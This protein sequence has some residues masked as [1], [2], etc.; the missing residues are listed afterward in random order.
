MAVRIPGGDVVAVE[1][2]GTRDEVRRHGEPVRKVPEEQS[3][4]VAPRLLSGG[5]VQGIDRLLRRLMGGETGPLVQAGG[6]RELRVFDVTEPA[7]LTGRAAR[8]STSR[9]PRGLEADG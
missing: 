2:L 1:D 3:D 6:R 7:F 4:D 8:R 9:P 5:E